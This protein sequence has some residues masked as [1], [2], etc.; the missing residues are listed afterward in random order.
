M[1]AMLITANPGTVYVRGQHNGT[2]DTDFHGHGPR[3]IVTARIVR[4]GNILFAQVEA[5]WEETES[6]Y[7]T[8]VGTS[9][10]VRFFD[11]SQVSHRA[12]IVTVNDNPAVDGVLEKPFR[13]V[14]HGY[15]IHRFPSHGLVG[16]W[17]IHG[18]RDGGWGGGPDRPFIYV[19]FNNVQVELAID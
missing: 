14:L 18:D 17:E 6:D 10:D 19:H 16:E 1:F 4:R 12:R 11:A 8:F 15:G 13:T 9:G 3:V 2:G 7:T 5:V